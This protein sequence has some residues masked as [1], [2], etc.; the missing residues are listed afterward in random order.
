MWGFWGLKRPHKTSNVSIFKDRSKV[1]GWYQIDTIR[2]GPCSYVGSW[3]TEELAYTQA[4]SS[5]PLHLW[6]DFF[7]ASIMY[8]MQN[9]FFEW[10]GK[11]TTSSSTIVT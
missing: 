9:L 4:T 2:F 6:K 1:N 11:S 5:I 3:T 10:L 8:Y 7:N